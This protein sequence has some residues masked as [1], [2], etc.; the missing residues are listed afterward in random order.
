MLL[1]DNNTGKLLCNR[2]KRI[3]KHGWVPP[4]SN[5]IKYNTNASRSEM[6]SVPPLAMFVEIIGARYFSFKEQFMKIVRCY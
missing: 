5:W 4:P 1:Q 2:N 6:P 3:S